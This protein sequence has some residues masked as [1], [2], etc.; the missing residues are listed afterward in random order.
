MSDDSTPTPIH[1]EPTEEDRARLLAAWGRPITVDFP[2]PFHTASSS[3]RDYTVA[4]LHDAGLDELV[5]TLPIL[6]ALIERGGGDGPVWARLLPWYGLAIATPIAAVVKAE[7]FEEY[8]AKRTRIAKMKREP[9]THDGVTRSVREWAAHQDLT[10][11]MVFGRVR[12]GW[13]IHEALGLVPHVR[14]VV[15][16]AV[17]PTK[18]SRDVLRSRR[19]NVARAKTISTKRMTLRDRRVGLA[20]YP[21]Q[22]GIDYHRPVTRGDCIDGVRPCPYVSCTANLY[23]DVMPKTGAIKI[24]F[25]D[26]EPHEMV[27]SC[28]LDVADRGGLTIEATGPL[29]NLTRERTRQII[30]EA[31]AVLDQIAEL[32]ERAMSEGRPMHGESPEN[33]DHED[34]ADEEHDEDDSIG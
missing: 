25:P 14:P 34:A 33:D 28:A 17:D 22:P 23:L 29:L 1:V 19:A 3:Q 24:N 11:R 10:L 30:V 2:A 16:K 27:E 7:S 15:A 12:I 4:H 26:L 31:E 32:R 5:A 18:P 9:V 6:E 21:E 13:S 8:E 20:L